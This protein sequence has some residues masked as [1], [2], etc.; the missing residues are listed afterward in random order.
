MD[1][2]CDPQGL[3]G[4]AD[5][6]PQRARQKQPTSSPQVS[7]PPPASPRTTLNPW[8]PQNL[9][10]ISKK[11]TQQQRCEAAKGYTP[12]SYIPQI[13]IVPTTLHPQSLGSSSETNTQQQQPTT[14]KLY[15]FGILW[16]K[17]QSYLR[18]LH[19][20]F[21][22][23]LQL[24]PPSPPRGRMPGAWPE[25]L[26]YTED[27]TTATQTPN[28][29]SGRS[30]DGSM[31]TSASQDASEFSRRQ[32]ALPHEKQS[33]NPRQSISDTTPLLPMSNI[34]GV[35]AVPQPGRLG[36]PTNDRQSSV[37]RDWSR[38][39]NAA[40]VFTTKPKEPPVNF[41]DSIDSDSQDEPTL[42]T[43]S[44]EEQLEAAPSG[45]DTTAKPGQHIQHQDPARLQLPEKHTV[46]KAVQEPSQRANKSNSRI[47]IAPGALAVGCSGL[48]Q[49]GLSVF[50]SGHKITGSKTHPMAT[51]GIPV[52]K[53]LPVKQSNKSMKR[54][55]LYP[56][57]QNAVIDRP[58]SSTPSVLEEQ[59]TNSSAGQTMISNLPQGSGNS[60]KSTKV[61]WVLEPTTMIPEIL[62]THDGQENVPHQLRRKNDLFLDSK[63]LYSG[64]PVPDSRNAQTPF[65]PL[66]D[67]GPPPPLPVPLKFQ[68][69]KDINETRA[70]ANAHSSPPMQGPIPGKSGASPATVTIGTQ[71]V[72]STQLRSKSQITDRKSLVT[73]SAEF[74]PKL[75]ASRIPKTPA[76]TG[77]TGVKEHKIDLIVPE[78]SKQSH[79]SSG[80]SPLPVVPGELTSE[81]ETSFKELALTPHDWE[82]IEAQG[83]SQGNLTEQ[84]LKCIKIFN[85][86]GGQLVTNVNESQGADGE[87]KKKPKK[88]KKKVKKNKQN[89]K[90]ENDLKVY[91]NPTFKSSKA[92][93]TGG[94]GSGTSSADYIMLP[95]QTPEVRSEYLREIVATRPT[96]QTT[97]PPAR[98]RTLNPNSVIMMPGSYNT[99]QPLGSAFINS[100]GSPKPMETAMGASELRL[101]S[102]PPFPEPIT[103][104]HVGDPRQP[105]KVT[106]P[107]LAPHPKRF[108]PGKPSQIGGLSMGTGTKPSTSHPPKGDSRSPQD[109]QPPGQSN[110]PVPRVPPIPERLSITNLAIPTAAAQSSAG[111]VS[112]KPE[113]RPAEQMASHIIASLERELMQDQVEAQYVTR[114]KNLASGRPLKT[115]AD[116]NFFKDYV[117]KYIEAYIMSRVVRIIHE[118]KGQSFLTEMLKDELQG[119]A[120]RAIPLRQIESE[121]LVDQ[122]LNTFAMLVTTPRT[123]ALAPQGITQQGSAQKPQK[124]AKKSA[125]TENIHSNIKTTPEIETDSR[126]TSVRGNS[127]VQAKSASSTSIAPAFKLTAGNT[128]GNKP[129][130]TATASFHRNQQELRGKQPISQKPEP[131]GNPRAP[132]R[133]GCTGDDEPVEDVVKE[134]QG[135]LRDQELQFL[136]STVE[137]EVGYEH[138]L[139]DFGKEVTEA[140]SRSSYR[141][142]VEMAQFAKGLA[143][144]PKVPVMEKKQDVPHISEKANITLQKPDPSTYVLRVQNKYSPF[145]PPF[146]KKEGKDKWAYESMYSDQYFRILNKMK[147]CKLPDEEVSFEKVRL[148]KRKAETK[149]SGC[150]VAWCTGCQACAGR[151]GSIK[152]HP[153]GQN[154]VSMS[155]GD[156]ILVETSVDDWKDTETF[157]LNP[158]TSS[159]REGLR[160][161]GIP[162][163]P[164]KGEDSAG[165]ALDHG[166]QTEGWEYEGEY[167]LSD[168]DD[169]DA[170]TLSSEKEEEL[171]N[172]TLAE[173]EKGANAKKEILIA[174][175][176]KFKAEQQKTMAALEALTSEFGKG[177]APITAPSNENAPGAGLSN[178]KSGGKK[179]KKKKGKK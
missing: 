46:Q 100:A 90:S 88:A 71:G 86:E 114:L 64:A 172:T 8:D 179:K 116:G 47:H 91:P 24:N 176:E 167:E 1:L 127:G 78:K 171:V 119:L 177:Q 17:I 147:E 101:H 67:L 151:N 98:L 89:G 26:F 150:G 48:Q 95:G 170:E 149:D 73:I 38:I 59:A 11:A 16:N 134:L 81:V 66:L 51:E 82:E 166:M 93:A 121:R 120:K 25:D 45:L 22:I 144:C 92:M 160:K 33:T 146:F 7:H 58:C 52:S 20:A 43:F 128:P 37:R 103:F 30:V 41:V 12:A 53:P 111:I 63:S 85:T 18:T 2:R 21:T 140:V 143:Y 118:F 94:M 4:G 54:P 154:L 62:P 13:S 68:T 145:E 39:V 5:P 157:T 104:M 3:T 148:G 169:D 125:F 10:L 40:L 6:V 173:M 9:D 138:H 133:P 49:Q 74:N 131:Q 87:E 132:V 29:Y 108:G 99:A 28:I 97:Q 57:K 15:F 113:G 126:S 152:S 14:S 110:T 124:E 135:T 61:P 19:E 130:Q 162:F 34:A 136:V 178:D 109:D 96:L 142:L 168:D 60:S 137:P 129:T 27:S 36:S 107:H 55:N 102:F 165:Y 112:S 175:L 84:D 44:G 174:E 123:T 153:R 23:A 156:T 72:T 105:L 80:T 158:V 56:E 115:V 69:G 35:G 139:E 31:G 77:K 50:T 159:T 70:A 32:E 75:G 83:H 122:F 155:N 65:P 76:F 163:K 164:F 141:Y 79:H 106:V 42:P 161:D 117:K